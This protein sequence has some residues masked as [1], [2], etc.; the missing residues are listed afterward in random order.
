MDI[1]GLKGRLKKA[2]ELGITYDHLFELAYKMHLKLFDIC[3]SNNL[4]VK[5]IYSEVGLTDTE[6][7]LFGYDVEQLVLPDYL[8]ELIDNYVKEQ[9]SES[10]KK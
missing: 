9:E 8:N 10:K 1:R 6:N 5:K 4:D 2:Q 3:N 7:E